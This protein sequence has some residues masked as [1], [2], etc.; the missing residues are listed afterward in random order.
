MRFI[1]SSANPLYAIKKWLK[2]GLENTVERFN[3]GRVG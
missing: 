1:S 3:E 2:R